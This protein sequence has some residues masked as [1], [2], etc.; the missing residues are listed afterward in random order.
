VVREASGDKFRKFRSRGQRISCPL[1]QLFSLSRPSGLC[2]FFG[3]EV[4][5]S[6][7]N[8]PLPSLRDDR[9][10]IQA[11]VAAEIEINAANN[12]FCLSNQAKQ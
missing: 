1:F 6:N 11:S 12:N 9:K 10:Q 7:V 5:S 2:T 3:P 4:S 8:T